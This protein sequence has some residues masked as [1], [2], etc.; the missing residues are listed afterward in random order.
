VKH[1]VSCLKHDGYLKRDVVCVS[2]DEDD[3]GEIDDDDDGG[4]ESDDVGVAERWSV[5]VSRPPH[6]DGVPC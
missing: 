3:K 4:D 2:D 6:R 1:H 5:V